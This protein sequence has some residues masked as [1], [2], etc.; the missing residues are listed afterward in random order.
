MNKFVR[1]MY[2]VPM[3]V[4]KIGFTKLFHIK[5]FH[6]SLIN[7]ISPLSEISLD[8]GGELS[9]GKM[10]KMRD[11]TK[12]R[13]RKN[14]KC[15]IGRNMQMG[16]NSIITCRDNISI[17]NDVEFAPNVYVYDHDHDFRA[18]GGLK[19][20][21]YKTKSIQIGNNVWIG[22]NVV[23]L[24]GAKIGDNCVIAAGSIVN[25]EIPADTVFVQLREKS[26][27]KVSG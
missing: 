7:M 4:I 8:Y 25:G 5:N 11:G 10:L 16:S 12:L 14:A 20:N 3:G 21:K 1:A 23:I 15:V 22:C 2:C 27:Y 18:D 24:K 19:S 17:G 26:I 6:G 13:V 9:I